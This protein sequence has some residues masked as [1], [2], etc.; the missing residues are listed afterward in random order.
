MSTTTVR[1]R[2][3]L[4]SRYTRNQA[5][6]RPPQVTGMPDLEQNRLGIFWRPI[7][8]MADSPF[9]PMRLRLI[10]HISGWLAEP[11]AGHV[12]WF[13]RIGFPEFRRQVLAHAGLTRYA[14]RTP[15]GLPAEL[16]T[17]QWQLLVDRLDDYDR[18]DDGTRALVVFHV[19]QLSFCEYA[20]DL[21]GVV[22]P[23]GDPA[24]DRLAYEV[25][26]VTARV[27]GRVRTALSVFAELATTAADRRLALAACAQGIS[28]AIRGGDDTELAETFTTYAT[29]LH[30]GDLD[31]WHGHL[32]RSRYHRAVA[33]LRLIQRRPVEMRA[34]VTTAL[35]HGNLLYTDGLGGTDRLVADENRR[36]ILESQ[37]KAAARAAGGETTAQL[38][39][40]CEA[41]YALDPY[42]QN[43]LL[44][45]G[46]GYA[47]A[48]Q[49]AE[50]AGWYTRAGEL[51]TA[52][53]AYGWYRAGQCFDLLGD[54]GSAVNAM[55]RCL[56]LDT[57][58]V[59]PGAYLAARQK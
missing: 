54:V 34:E 30:A 18:L 43:A 44:V 24:R 1:P 51:G 22:R 14:C 47:T 7:I 37:I 19:A 2:L 15:A 36:I 28:H 10:Q 50:A 8:D 41:L 39:G 57:T 35:Y 42:C 38:R 12:S 16:R 25:A 59:E 58:A 31:D 6:G 55:G 26:R 45:I 5:Y 27:P 29:A 52:G 11:A 20:A 4:Q 46:D 56:E 13:A 53:G 33:L 40:F 48:G 17:P 21:A 9:A 23:T 3:H 32:V 49:F